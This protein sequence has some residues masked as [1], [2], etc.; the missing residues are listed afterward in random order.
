MVL[1]CG[2]TSVLFGDATLAASVAGVLRCVAT[3]RHLIDGDVAAAFV[4][5][6]AHHSHP[7]M[8]AEDVASSLLSQ[9][10]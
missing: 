6:M 1:R 10:C 7:E 4:L 8:V 3:I 5:D 9:V 2:A